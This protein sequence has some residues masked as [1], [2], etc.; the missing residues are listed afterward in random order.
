MGPFKMKLNYK[1]MPMKFH[2]FL[3]NAGTAPLVPYLSTYAR[4]LGFSSA[5]VGLIYTILPIFALIAKPV[6][7][8]IADRFKLQKI[9]FLL[10]QAMTIVSFSAI[11]FIPENRATNSVQL[12]CAD[13]MTVLKTCQDGGS[14]DQCRF[15]TLKDSKKTTCEMNCDMS[16]PKMWQTV[17]EHWHIP[18][19]CDNATKRL[20]YS[21]HVGNITVKDKCAN[22]AT[23]NVILD[24]HNYT[25]RC[26]KGS[27][28]VNVTTPCSLNC[29]NERL[30]SIV[31]VQNTTMTCWDNSLDYRF[32]SD[33]ISHL[34]VKDHSLES[35]CMASCEHIE[36]WQLMEICNGWQSDAS[37]CQLETMIGKEFPTNLSFIGNVLP[38][39][40]IKTDKCLHVQLNYITL[41]D[42]ST[43][44]PKCTSSDLYQLRTELVHASCQINCKNSLLNEIFEAASDSRN[45]TSQ[46]TREFWLF[47]LFM[48]ISWVSQ[49]IVITI[50]DAICFELLDKNISDYGKQRLWGSLGYGLFSLITG[51]LID[52]FSDGAY[53]NYI[54]SFIL[55]FVYMCGDITVSL[56]VQTDTI[57]M[58]S[59]ILS[60][61]G[62]LMA[63][64]ATIVFLLWATVVGICTGFIWQFLF[65][66]L[67]DIAAQ[68][69]DGSDYIKTLEGIVTAVQSFGGEI[70]FL[71]VSGYVL[72]KVGH[73][74]MMSLVLFAFGVRF[75]LYSV[76]SNAWWVLPIEM[77][78]G[79]TYGMFYPAMTS[80]AKMV[81][82]DGTETTVQ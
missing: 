37:T 29:T 8:I 60:E 38:S 20:R 66:H 25:P 59:N 53:K 11:Y 36:P 7:G 14:V 55:M 71:F 62:T 73:I 74:N 63:S 3:F 46:Y 76:L 2:F 78:Q 27:G 33:N 50:A 26:H 80:Y 64:S 28:F 32:C 47:F 24:G 48:I 58:S 43:Y 1:L 35:E 81:S 75:L 5:T 68:S 19:Y 52:L 23:K 57:K 79:I 34:L 67:E 72:K 70:P 9:I 18:Q 45:N 13:G 17:C 16:S 30:S 41:P 10:F 6:L 39:T 21:S 44:Y 15:K 22:V 31:G 42:D 56:F 65:W 40:A 49:S 4:Q 69:C 54:V 82:P 61:V 12:D 51:A 77:L